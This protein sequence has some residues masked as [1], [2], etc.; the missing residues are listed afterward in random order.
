MKKILIPID[1]SDNSLNALAYAQL[2]FKRTKTTFYLFA[3]Y[4]PL[5]SN[6]MEDDWE[7]EWL[8]DNAEQ[9]III[10]LQEIISN[11]SHNKFNRLHDFKTVAKANS[12]VD[13]VKKAV[14]ELE[15]DFIV[16]GTKGAKG[17]KEY[18]LASNT[19][20]IVNAISTCP[21]I[22]VPKTYKSIDLPA[23]IV[24]STNL[25]RSFNSD[26][27][28]PLI[29]LL[30]SLDAKLKIVQLMDD[31]YLSEKQ[32]LH[33]ETLI[34]LL[35]ET[36]HFFHEITYTASETEAISEFVK[37]TQSDIISLIYHKQNFFY[38][39]LEENVVEK[40]TFNSEVPL[41]ILPGLN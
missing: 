30:L 25:K 15:I 32:K 28:R 9:E 3:A 11:L 4:Q 35:K 29:E 2:L 12:L 33:K 7:S 17:L 26:E 13:A 34:Y 38:E 5:P 40:S 36:P 41:L 37:G 39:L 27:L 23:Q 19:V 18:F 21:I 1:F 24:F 22:V 10:D 31:P 16:M 20:K 8:V 6:I 14:T